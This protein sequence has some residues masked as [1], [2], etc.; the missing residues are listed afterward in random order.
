MSRQ[1]WFQGTTTERK[2]VEGATITE[3]LSKRT[4][5]PHA[6]DYDEACEIFNN[7]VSLARAGDLQA[8]CPQ[9]ACAYLLAVEVSIFASNPQRLRPR[10]HLWIM[11]S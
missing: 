2:L 6:K 10:K 5:D 3:P 9:I 11:R 8:A 1:T 4:G 7:A